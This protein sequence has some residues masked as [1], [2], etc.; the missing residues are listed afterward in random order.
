MNLN[1]S[2][3]ESTIQMYSTNTGPRTANFDYQI[4]LRDFKELSNDDLKNYIGML[5]R[6]DL[7]DKWYKKYG[8]QQVFQKMFN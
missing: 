5:E 7:L 6:T 3:S 1:E 4:D 8:V 2:R